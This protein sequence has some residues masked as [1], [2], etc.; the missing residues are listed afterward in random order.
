MPSDLTV[1]PSTDYP[2]HQASHRDPIAN[3]SIDPPA[4]T[5]SGGVNAPTESFLIP[6]IMTRTTSHP[7]CQPLRH[8]P[9]EAR[10]FLQQH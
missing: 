4:S 7:R 10:H 8:H 5:V 6:R 1:H 2:A 9:S 3:P